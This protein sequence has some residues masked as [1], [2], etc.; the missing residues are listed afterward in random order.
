MFSDD[1]ANRIHQSPA[2]SSPSREQPRRP[3]LAVQT[4]PSK[5]SSPPTQARRTSSTKPL[6][7]PPSPRSPPTDD[8]TMTTTNTSA[9]DL[10]L[11]NPVAPVL[12]SAEARSARRGTPQ[13]R[14]SSPT[15]D[16]ECLRR[17]PRGR[18]QRRTSDA[19]QRIRSGDGLRL[20]RTPQEHRRAGAQER[21][22]HGLYCG[23]GDWEQQRAGEA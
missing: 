20:K 1:A 10:S 5:P 4:S 17:R 19:S 3:N 8:T 16:R 6:P 2:T 15:Q 7:G 18:P 13:V 11:T 22:Q 21:P 9:P 12:N 23:V 14:Q